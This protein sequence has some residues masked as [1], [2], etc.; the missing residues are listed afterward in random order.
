MGGEE[1][2]V[3]LPQTAIEDACTMAER[4]RR[5]VHD[6]LIPHAGSPTSDFVS[7]SAGVSE[8]GGGASPAQ[9]MAEADKA[10]YR[11]KVSGRNRVEMSTTT[12]AA[13]SRLSVPA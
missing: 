1:F 5:S 13:R 12:V 7:I 8:Y 11:A 2:A 9:V 3:V 4:M 6:L 10:L